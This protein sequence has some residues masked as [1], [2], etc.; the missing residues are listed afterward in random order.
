[1]AKMAPRPGQTKPPHADA[2][3][4]SFQAGHGTGSSHPPHDRVTLARENRALSVTEL[5]RLSGMDRNRNLYRHFAHP[6]RLGLIERVGATE[7]PHNIEYPYALTALGRAAA[8]QL[9]E[10]PG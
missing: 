6:S 7:R 9:T 3:L 1:M 2:S 8:R 4:I 10:L 5:A